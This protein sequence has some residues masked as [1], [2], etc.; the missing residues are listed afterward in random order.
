M[1]EIMHSL[2][3]NKALSALFLLSDISIA[4][5]W[6]ASLKIEA[7]RSQDDKCAASSNLVVGRY[8]GMLS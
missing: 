3:E 1:R 2:I 7:R 4:G 5:R 8:I 6:N